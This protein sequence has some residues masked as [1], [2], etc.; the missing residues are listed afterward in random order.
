MDETKIKCVLL[1]NTL[2]ECSPH[3]NIGKPFL[4]SGVGLIAGNGLVAD[5]ECV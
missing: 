2:I 1:N 4:T 5:E 3:P